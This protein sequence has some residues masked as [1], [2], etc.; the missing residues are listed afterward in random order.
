M[1]V[2]VDTTMTINQDP[3]ITSASKI[4]EYVPAV[5]EMDQTWQTQLISVQPQIMS[6]GDIIPSHYRQRTGKLMTSDT[7]H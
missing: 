4:N 6:F 2:D 5:D 7:C 1:G 3:Q